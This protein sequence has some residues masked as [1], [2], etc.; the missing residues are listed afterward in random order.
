MN[1][2]VTIITVTYNVED[3]IKETIES[4]I[5]QTYDNVELVI[6]DGGSNDRTLEILKQYESNISVL[7][8]ESDKGIFDA[9]NRGLDLATG[10][11]VNFMNAGDKL[12]K[13][14]ILSEI[15][16]ELY[17]KESIGVIYGNT[18]RSGK[19]L[20]YPFPLN[21]IETGGMPACH[22][23]MFFNLKVLKDSLKFKNQY[24]A[25]NRYGDVELVARLYHKGFTFKYLDKVISDNSAAG[26]STSKSLR[27]S[28]LKYKW[29]FQYFGI[30]NLIK[31][32]LLKTGFKIR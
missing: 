9:M 26:S 5:N 30:L 7:V 13:N 12:S 28:Y 22:Q 16:F 23:S 6:V 14:T 2:K 10:V 1:L 20:S 17:A 25:L 11:W 29:V 27:T 3:I 32:I 19:R 18:L 31:S 21:S 8:S 24:L 15:D 4:I